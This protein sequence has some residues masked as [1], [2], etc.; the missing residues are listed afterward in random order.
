MKL[1]ST[2]YQ[3]MMLWSRHRHAPYYL[4]GLSFA[5][6]SVFPIPPDVML[7]PMAL[8]RP[9]RAWSYALL[10]TLS[11]VLGGIF[12]YC[13]G[14]F[15]FSFVH[16]YIIQFGYEPMYQQIDLWFKAWGFWI[17]FIAGF[18]PI[19][20]KLFTIAAGA[21][22]MPLLPFIIASCI[23]RGGRFYLVSGLM[24]WGGPKMEKVLKT[25]IDRL[26][27]GLLIILVLAY[28]IIHFSNIGHY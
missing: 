8:A 5:E 6:S 12:G 13:I 14:M 17:I 16:P 24:K 23:G 27:W 18:A 2:L 11:S 19:P 21:M 9:E 26:G 4:F 15:F 10:T 1:F 25:Y 3:W 28:L 22:G 20:Y 7:A